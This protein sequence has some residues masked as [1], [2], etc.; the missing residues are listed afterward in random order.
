MNK[1]SFAGA[2]FVGA[3]AVVWV[4]AGYAASHPLALAMTLI[5]GGVYGLGA[6]ELLQFRRATRTVTAALANIPQSLSREGLTGWLDTLH[7]TLQ[8]AVRLRV[9]G[10][11]T[12]LPGPALT[13]YLVGLLVMLG[14][15]GTFLGM[16]VTLNGAVFALEGTT[17][18][19]AM[20]SSL[21]APIKGLG[22]A[23]GTSLAGVAASAMLGL[24]SALVRRERLQ[25][26]QVLDSTIA[27][28]FR[29][30]SL[31]HQRQET[32]TALQQQAQAL[33]NVV[34]S[35]QTLMTLME[36]QNQ[37]LQERL[38][39]NQD[40]FHSH[41]QGVYTGLAQAV[42]QSLKDSLASA[43]RVAMEAIQPIAEATLTGMAR[44]ATALH[45]RLADTTQ[46][47]LDA[48]LTRIDASASSGAREAS[49]LHAR[50]VNTTQTQLDA[51]TA[52][53]EASAST[54]A[55]SWT[56]ALAQQ[57]SS[58]R[59]LLQGLEQSHQVFSET[60]EER[61]ATLLAS[62][63]ATLTDLQT[64]Q[65]SAN[66]QQ[67][68]AWTQSL[69]SV[70]G[71]LQREWQQAGAHSLAQQ[72]QICST[73]EA[74]ARQITE[75]AQT[76]AHATLAE[77]TRLL[78]TVAEAPRAAADV[79]G[80][81]RHELSSSMARDNAMLEER[82]RI[83]ETLSGLLDT[84][85]H[86]STEQ[87]AS[88]DTLVA[89]SAELLGRVGSQFADKVDVE[90]AR[91]SGSAAHV[92]SSAVEVASMGEAFQFAVQ[93][94]NQ[95]NDKLIANLQRIEA[96]M[97]K[98]MARSDDQLAYYVAQAREIIDL[99]LTSQKEVV[100]DLRALRQQPAALADEVA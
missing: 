99:S 3:L 92:T 93:L 75:Q 36:R 43:A 14:M 78:D 47:Q 77:I 7:P 34:N 50:M 6:F 76:H 40:S 46:T 23:F 63:G 29:A 70:A 68:G 2:F 8:N 15:L 53:V 59:Q 26:G 12:G 41:V 25:A 57:D 100:D 19:S 33:P 1:H 95:A 58:N 16:V 13:P 98:S 37:Q 89:S 97:D 84:I 35:L 87:R 60:F 10:E 96:A 66:Q 48:L 64:H 86:A 94:F 81:L 91:L 61:S 83:L 90:A 88:I 17:D 38:L 54:M 24:M 67:L 79:I 80:Q 74:T 39:G 73:L 55:Q 52:R 9:E 31:A 11:R 69:E 20:R 71:T 42:D 28:E 22:L 85:Q 32:F 82:R 49:A 5:I 62:V 44:E 65:A 56:A 21:A 45:A 27:T 4:G 51:L 72:Q 30:F 18:L